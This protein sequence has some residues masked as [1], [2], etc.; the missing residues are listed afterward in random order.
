MSEKKEKSPQLKA[1]VFL[2]VGLRKNK[3]IF[4]L[5]TFFTKFFLNNSLFCSILQKQKRR[6]RGGTFVIIIIIFFHDNLHGDR[7]TFPRVLLYQWGPLYCTITSSGIRSPWFWLISISTS[8]T[9]VCSCQNAMC[10][11]AHFLILVQPT[12]T[13]MSFS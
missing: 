12:T 8:I 3:G 6:H 10:P 11:V 5:R 13:F 1:C 7:F 4:G 2:Q 9:D